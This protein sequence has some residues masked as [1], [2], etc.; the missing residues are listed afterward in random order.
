MGKIGDFFKR[1]GEKI[2]NYFRTLKELV[3]TADN[4]GG[5]SLED[6][7]KQA[8]LSAEDSK[9]LFKPVTA[10]TGKP[11]LLEPV[12]VVTG[13]GVKTPASVDEKTERLYGSLTR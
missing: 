2:S 6:E 1:I 10:G 12:Q 4:Y 9:E 5:D 7:A 13:Q 11:N 3:W 8:G